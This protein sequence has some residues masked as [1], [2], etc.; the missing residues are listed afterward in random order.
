ML[1]GGI[2][3]GGEAVVDPR[4]LPTGLDHARVAK[5]CQV[6]GGGRLGNLESPLDMANTQLAMREQGDYPEAGLIA[7]GL[8][9]AGKRSKVESRHIHS[10][11]RM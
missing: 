5:D 9:E 4:A 7:Q 2:R 11:I 10:N 8:V 1:R 6:P 3:A